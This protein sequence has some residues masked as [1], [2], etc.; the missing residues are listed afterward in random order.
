MKLLDKML[1][2]VKGVIFSVVIVVGGSIAAQQAFAGDFKPA[3]SDESLDYYTSHTFCSAKGVLLQE[4]GQE[5]LAGNS[6]DAVF[7]DHNLL[8]N[9]QANFALTASSKAEVSQASQFGMSKLELASHLANLT[10]EQEVNGH[11]I[12]VEGLKIALAQQGLP[13]DAYWSF[14]RN[15]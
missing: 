1:V 4:W 9:D 8:N 6:G 12:C 3:M 13:V 5:V 2:V 15:F 10:A 14:V 7:R 11:T